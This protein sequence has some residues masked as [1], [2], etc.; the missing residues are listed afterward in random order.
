MENADR[1]AMGV[2][3][4]GVNAKCAE[5]HLASKHPKKKK[6]YKQDIWRNLDGNGCCQ[7]H[8]TGSR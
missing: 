2:L 5:H 6:K 7:E 3:K 8:L 1:L 4:A